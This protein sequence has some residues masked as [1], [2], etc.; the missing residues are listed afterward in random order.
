MTFHDALRLAGLRPKQ[1]IQDGKIHRCPTE[2][3]PRSDNGW[4]SYHSDGH[5]VYGDWSINGGEAL[6]TWR[7]EQFEQRMLDPTFA[8]RVQAQHEARRAEE[9]AQRLQAIHEVRAYWSESTRPLRAVHPYVAGKGLTP[10]GCSGMR[11]ALK[12]V[13]YPWDDAPRIRRADLIVPVYGRTGS[14]INLQAISADGRKMIWLGAP[15]KGGHLILERPGG[16][17]LTVI[18]EGVATGL[19]VLQS[20]RHARVVVA[21]T[22]GNMARVVNVLKPHGSVVIAADNDWRTALKPH[23]KGRNPGIADAK[24]AAQSIG[25]GVT[26]PQGI[27]GSDWADM[28]KEHGEGAGRRIERQ[29]QA[30]ARYVVRE[31]PV[32]S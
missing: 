15:M 27:E 1:V 25:A 7:D 18:V 30:A 17:G 22:A 21:F 32:P 14:L 20:M 19:A 12:P 26:W 8:A 10:Q 4:Y 24:A 29:I 13:Q 16:Y 2:S 6:G 11:V 28:L 9:R 23:M 31:A 5:G 3:H